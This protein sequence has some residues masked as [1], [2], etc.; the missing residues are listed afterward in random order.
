V[1]RDIFTA[2]FVIAWPIWAG[3]YPSVPAA[4]EALREH[5]SQLRAAL[6]EAISQELGPHFLMAYLDVRPAGSQVMSYTSARGEP[7][8]LRVQIHVQAPEETARQPRD[9]AHDIDR[10]VD[11][12]AHALQS[13]AMTVM[14]DAMQG[15]NLY[16][17]T[18][19]SSIA[20]DLVDIPSRAP[21]PV[22]FPDWAITDSDTRGCERWTI[23]ELGDWTI[24]LSR[25]VHTERSQDLSSDELPSIVARLEGLTDTEWEAHWTD[26]DQLLVLDRTPLE[27]FLNSSNT[28]I[29]DEET[30]T[31]RF[32]DLPPHPLAEGGVYFLLMR[33]QTSSSVLASADLE[34]LTD[35]VLGIAR[36][37][38]DQLVD[39]TSVARVA[40]A[41]T[42]GRMIQIASQPGDRPGGS[43]TAYSRR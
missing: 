22:T 34:E 3:G 13:L 29:F 37:R 14:P 38:L 25:A 16:E 1:D 2:T 18:A 5:V 19:R 12:A 42:F 39:V 40:A 11:H 41:R 32:A 15:A 6:V 7:N 27:A 43:D 23:E 17:V 36:A 35:Q 9:W 31:V 33:R 20:P 4:V 30:Q 21:L 10:T 8:S 26:L 24:S 28:L